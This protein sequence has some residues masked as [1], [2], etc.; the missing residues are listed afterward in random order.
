MRIL[1][2]LRWVGALAGVLLGLT[3]CSDSQ[4]GW[5]VVQGNAAFQRGDFQKAALHYLSAQRSGESLDV[6][7]YNLGNVYN[8]LG[9]T[10]TA[11][12]IWNRISRPGS[13]ELAY[14]LAFNRGYLLYQR[15]QYDQACQEFRT[16]LMMKPSSLDAKRNLE[17]SLL[18]TQSFGSALPARPR[19]ADR[20][21]PGE[22]QKALLEYI[23]RLEG[24]RWKAN[25]VPDATPASS[26][27]W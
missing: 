19:V 1:L 3:S 17:I 25:N 22:T 5:A 8:A 14:R 7:N 2:P 10:N 18:K 9:E 4:D 26:S 16:A 24:T 21:D 12:S 11:L 6:V 23:N 27:D 13:D 15:G 20:T